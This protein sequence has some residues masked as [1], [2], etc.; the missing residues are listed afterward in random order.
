MAVIRAR[1][2]DALVRDLR[3]ATA[4]APYRVADADQPG[5]FVVVGRRSKAFAAQANRRA[6]GRRACTIKRVL[7]YASDMSVRVA[8]GAAREL[9]GQV[10]RGED[11][12][13]PK[14]QGAGFTLGQTW[15][16][17]ETEHLRRLGRS[18]R[19]IANYRFHV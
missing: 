13:A 2:T 14:Q 7:G 18:D 1:L 6:N 17:Y 4:G 3:M 19:T 5:L 8:R 15:A 9:L 11:P 12:S 16:L 10:A